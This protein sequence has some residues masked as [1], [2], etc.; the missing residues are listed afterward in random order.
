M[1]GLAITYH[2]KQSDFYS[3]DPVAKMLDAMH[4]RGNDQVVINHHNKCIVGF[5]RLAITELNEAQPQGHAWKVYLSGEIYNYKELGFRGSECSVISQGLE[6]Y[7][8]DFVKRLNGMFF[9]VAI[10]GDDVFVFRDRYGIKPVYYYES[11]DV[12]VIASEAKAIAKHP[13]YKFAINGSAKKQWF[14]FNNVLTDETLFEGIYKLNKGTFWHVNMDDKVQYWEWKFEP[15]ESMDP[16]YALQRLRALIAQAIERQIPNEVDYAS[17]LSGGVDSNIIA[18]HLDKSVSMFTVGFEGVEDERKMAKLSGRDNSELIFSGVSCFDK[19]IF[20]LEDL[21]VGAS[22]SSY[23]LYEFISNCGKKVCFDGAGADELFGGYVWRYK[24]ENYYDI[25]N[26]TGIKDEYCE[27]LFKQVFPEDTLENR[28]AFDANYFLEGVLLAV[29]KLSMAHTLEVRLPFL[30]NDLVDFCLT[31]PNKFKENKWILK[32]AFRDVLPGQIIRG[33]KKGFSSPDW[34]PGEGN[35]ALKWATA[36][37]NEW[38]KQ[39]STTN[40]L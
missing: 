17:C 6:M 32:R 27:E 23:C 9:I 5:R 28:Y 8:E 13:D 24:A 21:R 39:Y 26:R 2:K 4:H 29:E 11:H 40:K 14:V 20:H 18:A 12:I 25:V 7:G 34:I 22:W 35:Q 31:L 38:E 15:D 30:D 10:N 33:S 16:E 19:T 36:A 1:C 37:Y 3:T